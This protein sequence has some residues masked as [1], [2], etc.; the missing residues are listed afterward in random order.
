MWS[1]QVNGKPTT[2]LEQDGELLIPLD[3]GTARSS[4][5]FIYGGRYVPRKD[6]KQRE[7]AGP[8]FGLPLTAISWNLYVPDTYRYH[9]FDG[10]MQFREDAEQTVHRYNT[11]AYT[12]EA[13]RKSDESLHRA[14][15]VMKLGAEYA[16]AGQH[17]AAKKAFEAAMYYSQGQDD[18]NE[19]ARIQYRNLARRQ[20]VAGLVNRRGELKKRTYGQN[21]DGATITTKDNQALNMVAE[22]LI[23]QQAA[24]AELATSINV[25]L[26]ISGRKLAFYRALQI[27]PFAPLEIAYSAEPVHRAELGKAAVGVMGLVVLLLLGFGIRKR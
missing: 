10:S 1:V 5:E 25:T 7:V 22:K 9:D 6:N 27:E 20:A 26:P 11:D 23:D 3:A 24:A 18:F 17:T 21:R 14:E 8:Q 13:R 15:E 19:D 2:P 12:Q 4:I 16:R